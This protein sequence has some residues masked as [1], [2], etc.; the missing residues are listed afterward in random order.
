[1]DRFARRYVMKFAY[2]LGIV[3]L[4]GA[5]VLAQDRPAKA[6]KGTP[7]IA[8]KAK[9]KTEQ[10]ETAGEAAFEKVVGEAAKY[11]A[12]SPGYTVDVAVNW[13]IGEAKGKNRFLLARKTPVSFRVE[14]HPGDV[15][16]AAL[17]TA[18]NGKTI[19]TYLPAKELY[20]VHPL[21]P[22][23]PFLK[24]NAM[25]SQAIEGS[26]IELLLNPHVEDFV[27]THVGDIKDLGIKTFAK[28]KAHGFSMK[29][30]ARDVE[31]WIAAEGPPLLIGFKRIS[32][33]PA[34]E[35]DD[36][37]PPQVL[38]AV[39]TWNVEDVPGDKT[40][41]V[42]VPKDAKKVYDIYSELI[43][44]DESELV[45]KP[46]PK[47][48]VQTLDGT[49]IEF[50]GKSAAHKP[51]VL[52]LWAT[53]CAPAVKQMPAV[54]KFVEKYQ[55]KGVRFVAVNVEEDAHTVHQFV[56]KFQPKSE[57]A[58]DADGHVVDA[59]GVTHLPAVLVVGEDGVVKAVHEDVTAES[60]KE[61]AADL[62]KLSPSK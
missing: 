48:S 20:S 49:K 62:E 7:K 13:S 58:I 51:S 47:I 36:A 28:Q 25:L 40:F 9:P 34:L 24:H 31:A 39:L 5:S 18:G 37:P 32:A 14:A 60:L 12:S 23:D 22:K 21:D 29:W 15:K 4:L 44:D 41:T 33:A 53:W 1:M 55:A 43:R 46:A 38:D 59:L 6:P 56:E 19:T 17:I 35:G 52:I 54:T 27:S 10:V 42:D 8:V 50:G 16:T 61:L 3:A 2:A 57:I 30:G 11:L 45:G 26:G